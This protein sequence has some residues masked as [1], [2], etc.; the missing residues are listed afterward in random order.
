M[1]Q[2][3][4]PVPRSFTVASEKEANDAITQFP[5]SSL[6]V[7]SQ[8]LA[9]GRGRGVFKDGFKGG[10][11]VCED[12]EEAVRVINRMLGNVLV[13]KQSGDSGKKVEKVMVAEKVDVKREMYLALL[14]DGESGGVVFVVSQVGGM[15]IED[16]AKKDPGAV[17]KVVVGAE[18]IDGEFGERVVKQVGEALGFEGERLKEV[19]G[20]VKGLYRLFMD[21]DATMVEINPLVETES[22]DVVCVDAK[23]KLD[24]NAAFRQKDIFDM[25]DTSQEDPRELRA[26]KAGL[27]YIGLDGNI[28]CMVNGAG[29]A[30]ATMD[31]IK[32]HGGEPANFLDVGGSATEEQ[33]TEAFRILNEDKQVEAILVNIF[34]GIM[35][36][37]VIA[38]G[39]ISAA[40]KLDMKIPLV[41]RLQGNMVQKAKEMLK[42]SGLRIIPADDLD[43]AA[44]K[45]CT[46]AEIVKL[47]RSVNVDVKF[48]APTA[49]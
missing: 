35:R 44:D 42:E 3:R 24:D 14:N 2:F 32:N 34:G 36:C 37:D 17:K 48:K 15:S 30:M 13:T 26:D 41:V 18:D 5:S 45:A 28:G 40:Q 47:A 27:N 49:M 10:V 1:R 8:I 11:H 22:G 21:K 9:G 31:I 4:I 29:L 46:L 6:V 39:I 33:V 19:E 12:K 23:I 25:R 43:E 38:Q 16:V 7:K 20:V